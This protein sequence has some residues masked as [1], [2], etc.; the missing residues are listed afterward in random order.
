[1]IATSYLNM[2]M[3]ILS[4]AFLQYSPLTNINQKNSFNL[5]RIRSKEFVLLIQGNGI[6]FWLTCFQIYVV[7]V[8]SKGTLAGLV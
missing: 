3:H 1:M 2:L 5:L 7:L 8:L 4:L 6:S